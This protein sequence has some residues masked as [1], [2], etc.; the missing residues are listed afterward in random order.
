MRG[1]LKIAVVVALFAVPSGAFAASGS[2][3]QVLAI[4]CNSEQ[5]KPMRIVISCGD[6]SSWLGKLKW[7]S[8]GR[9]SAAASGTYKAVNCTPDCAAG[10]VHS[11]AIEL[12]LSKPKTCPGQTHSAFKQATLTYTTGPR[13]KGAPAKL[14]LRCP[15]QLPGEY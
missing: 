2:P 14:A 1:A 13:P 8:W 10:H 6:G 4:N 15:P 3:G 7:S 11:Y 9:K 12:T 5:Y